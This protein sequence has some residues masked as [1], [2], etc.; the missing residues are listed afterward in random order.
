MDRQK[1]LARLHLHAVLP[2]MAKIVEFDREAQAIVQGWNAA[3]QFGYV[4]GPAMQLQFADGACRAFRQAAVKPDVN[5]V[6]PLPVLLNNMLAGKGFTLP[7]INGFWNVKLLKGFMALAK[8]MEYYLK[9]LEGKPLDDDLK[10]KV[11]TCK[12]AVA[13]WGSA[14]LAECDPHF[15]TFAEHIPA[16]GSINFVVKPD[17]PNFYFKKANNGTFLAGDGMVA[18]PSA[19]VSF[20]DIH[21]AAQLVDGTLDVM[22]ALGK[23]EVVVRG[24]IPMVDDVSAIMAKLETYLA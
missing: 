24:L 10:R 7:L 17:G 8:R 18:D 6:F 22:A 1:I 20:A 16:G 21:V 5:F 3:I 12:L 2:V 13:T 9:E 23:Q 4:G 11:L 19:E 15:A 14:I